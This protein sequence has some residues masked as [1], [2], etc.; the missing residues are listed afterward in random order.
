M[1]GPGSFAARLRGRERLVGYWVACDSLVA[2]ERIARLGYDYVGVDGQHG[3]VSRGAWPAAM[4]AV[5]AGQ[6]SAGVLRVG[7]VDG[8]AIG[9]ALDAGARA[10]IVPMVDSAADAEV[11][12]RATRHWPAGTRSVAGPVR[13]GLRLGE[14]PGDI[15]DAVACVVMIETLAALAD[16]DAICATP[17]LGG[18]Y[19]GPAD[20]SVALGARYFGD[21]AAR[22]ALLDAAAAIAGAAKAAGIGC[23]IHCMDGDSAARWLSQGYTF[24]TVSSDITH[25]EQAAASHLAAARADGAA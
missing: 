20:L 21:P 4:L 2:T 19:L 13:A 3:V 1:T 24:A 8:T 22:G 9:A 14:V 16:L 25:L 23:G 18:V 11:A 6:C 12:V 15:D 5:D 10:V 17:G 7:S